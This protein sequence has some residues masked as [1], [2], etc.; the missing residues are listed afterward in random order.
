MCGILGGLNTQFDSESLSCLT[1]RGPDQRAISTDD[2]DGLGRLTFGQTRL[3][4]VDREDVALPVRIG[5]STI[6]FNGEIYNYLELRDELVGL[7]WQF[8]TKTDTEVALAAYLQWGPAC[9][10]RF[11]GMF[12]M[13]VWDGRHFFLARDRLGKKPLFYRLGPRS[14][15][16]ASTVRSFKDLTFAGHDL[17][18]LF[19]FTF[20]EHT[21][22][23][24]IFSLRPGHYLTYDGSRGTCAVRSYWDI[25]ERI[26]GKIA[27]ERRAVDEFIGLLEDAVRLR[28][29]A[30]VPVSLFLSG[31]LDSALLARCA[32]VNEAFTCQFLEFAGTID[33]EGYA[34]DL[35]A[36]LG[37]ACRVLHPTRAE[38]VHDLPDL[39][40]HL[41]MPTGSFSVFPLYCLARAAHE[42]GYKVVLTGDGS[43]ELFGGYARTEFLLADEATADGRR[44]DYSAMLARYRGS[45]LDRFCR[46][47]SRSGLQ[48]AALMK[49]F[50]SEYWS[51]RKSLLDNAS[52]VE[53]RIF[54]QPLLQM[55][56]RMTMA[57]SVEARCPYLD[58]RLVEFAFSL[59][60]S[61]RYRNG[62]GKWLVHRAAERLLPP[63]SAVLTRGVKHGLATP[64]NLW[65]QGRHSFDRKHWNTLMTSEC[66]KS[67]HGGE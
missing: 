22:F 9:L 4:V 14:F 55:T 37:I 24:D 49:M 34:R 65:T 51:E 35:C 56:D 21:L 26:D 28:L 7:G 18:A 8:G 10:D 29:R 48:G 60:D 66:L 57:H 38:F 27:D 30:D 45:D 25:E 62:T 23:R 1:H 53:T 13:A 47:A 3:N 67:F 64:I 32:G 16:F 5:A 20:N 46:M 58:H 43:D 39:A 31:G 41:E 2:V 15:E 42:T 59:D 12:A 11:N 54:L 61:L 63:G 19:E 33:E 6:L 40:Y 17:F 52:Y 50:L 36:R 44:R